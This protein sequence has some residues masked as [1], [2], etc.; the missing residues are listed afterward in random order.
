[1]PPNNKRHN[2]YTKEHLHH[3]MKE[4]SS[5][6]WLLCRISILLRL[7]IIAFQEQR[8]FKMKQDVG[9]VVFEHLGDELHVH[10]L[11]IN[12]LRRIGKPNSMIDACNLSYLKALVH[13]NDCFV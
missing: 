11:D 8:T 9:L 3:I 12:L 5:Y 6:P 2:K 1:M 4:A 10:V 13:H 7:L